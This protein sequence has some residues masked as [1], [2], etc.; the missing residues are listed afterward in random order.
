MIT[1]I[2]A[3]LLILLIVA[4]I[5]ILFYDSPNQMTPAQITPEQI[6]SE[7]IT[8]EQITLQSEHEE[9]H[10]A[11]A[12]VLSCMDYRFIGPTIKHLYKRNNAFDFDYFVLAGA[13]L[14][15]NESKEPEPTIEIPE[16]TSRSWYMAFEDHLRLARRLHDIRELICVDHEGCAMYHAI[17][18]EE[19]D[20]HV[21]EIHKHEYNI[22]KF[23]ET[24]KNNPE[25]NDLKYTGLLIKVEDPLRFRVI[26]EEST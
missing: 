24:L 18:G 2:I 25:F 14:G 8:P 21:K 12:L 11:H 1:L 7:Q 4:L 10:Q 5:V 3:L 22:H 26:Y 16:V 13:S 19:V 20:T 15:Y 17:Y 9:K 23:I 6:T